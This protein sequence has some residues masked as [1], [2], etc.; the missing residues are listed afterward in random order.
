MWL[1]NFR[2]TSFPMYRDIEMKGA[3]CGKLCYDFV[4]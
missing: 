2:L 4:L 1:E 3:V